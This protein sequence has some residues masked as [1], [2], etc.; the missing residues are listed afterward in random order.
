[1]PSS[2]NFTTYDDVVKVAMT[3][4]IEVV[5]VGKDKKTQFHANT[6]GLGDDQEIFRNYD[7]LCVLLKCLLYNLKTIIHG[8]KVAYELQKANNPQAMQF[9]NFK[10]YV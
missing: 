3:L 7:G 8:K 10:W 5:M 4:F 9:Y 6:L 2:G 1:M